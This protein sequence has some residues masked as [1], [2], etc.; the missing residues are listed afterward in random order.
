MG[1][2]EPAEDA[3]PKAIKRSPKGNGGYSYNSAKGRWV[4]RLTVHD[5]A[6]NAKVISRSARTEKQVQAKLRELLNERD[7]NA[8]L[9]ARQQ[10]LQQFLGEWLESVK[11]N[12]RPRTYESYSYAVNKHI[13][14]VLGGR[15]LGALTPQHVQ[16]FINSEVG[17]GLAP[18][19]VRH[20]YRI[21]KLA[22][23]QAIDWG[24]LSQNAARATRLP[25]EV[26]AEIHPLTTEELPLFLRAITGHRLETLY[27]LALGLGLRR[28][29]V[30]ALQ[31]AD[32]NLERG[33]IEIRNNLQ[34][35]DGK[36]V[37]GEPKTARGRRRLQLAPSLLASLRA[38]RERQE[39]E[40]ARYG[41]WPAN[42]FIFTT[43]RGTPYLP[44]V[45]LKQFKRMLRLNGLADR[46]FHDLRHTF[47]TQLYA[48]GVPIKTISEMAGHSSIV[49]TLNLY[50]HVLPE[51]RDLAVAVIERLLQ[52]DA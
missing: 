1:R 27:R 40:R 23:K 7:R 20:I 37:L 26:R 12:V 44:D 24:I 16:Q 45:L 29:E 2:Q 10:T 52:G 31:W 18:R 14:P 8:P 46:R 43:R 42:D 22:L 25:R 19:T 39:A 50:A 33:E 48:R 17:A 35:I 4:A 9:T 15:M 38:Q 5:A 47:V 30:L 28:G 32:V 34:K 3:A 13:L 51:Q 36:L 11:N 21:L 41:D 6:G 49:I